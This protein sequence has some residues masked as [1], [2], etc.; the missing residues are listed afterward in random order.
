MRGLGPLLRDA[1]RLTLPYFRSEER[2]VAL[3]LLALVVG[4]SLGIVGINVMLSYWSRGFFDA[5]QAK[6]VDSFIRLLLL[7][8][9]SDDSLQF[10]FTPLA[11]V[12]VV[13]GIYRTYLNQ[14]LQIR[15]RNWLT[16]QLTCDWLSDRAYWRIALS[17][18]NAGGY[19]TD[20]PDQRIA[21]DLK[22]FVEDTLELALGL[23]SST[24][25]LFSFVAILWTLS[26]PLVVLGVDIPGH[27]V[28]LA[29]MYAAVASV[30][31]EYVGRPLAGLM[32]RQ[33]RVE[34]D[35]R[36]GLARLRENME[37]I[38]LYGGEAEE[39][40]SA[41][42]R[43]AAVMA[44]WRQIMTRTKLL[45]AVMLGF[46]QTAVIFPYLIAAPTY[47]A[48]SGT[49]GGMMQT[50]R[51][52]GQVERAMLWFVHAYQSLA[53]WRATVERLAAFSEAIVA[54]RV[55]DRGVA[56]VPGAGTGYEVDHLTLDLPDGR[57]LV[58]DQ[59]LSMLP[60]EWVALAGRSG[61][62]KST[63]FRALA[64]IWPFGAGTVREPASRHLFLPQRPYLP[65]GTL[66]RA[67][68]YPDPIDAHGDAAVLEVLHAVGLGHL[69]ASLDT[70]EPWTQRLSGGEQQRIAIARALLI[71]PDWLFLDEATSSLD[72]QSE[73]ELY[74]LLRQ[75][76]P[77]AA[78][79]SIAH[80][81]AVAELHARHIV[82]RDGALVPG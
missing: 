9:W 42:Q 60:G 65:L 66:R 17:A 78:I 75:R 23:L 4:L 31:T 14:M 16:A 25:T 57:R 2:W 70:E 39:Q 38:A 81:P 49:F 76:L 61:T 79:I 7:W 63:L 24:V 52:F 20:N 5:I 33:Q 37:G 8:K 44:N 74:E 43:F 77:H 55:A 71:K 59:A 28:W 6:D 64:G 73:A 3:G 29:L 45:N 22:K 62:G 56:L 10:G 27:M 19:G 53:D 12:Y 21:E 13:V 69:E 32:F 18:G 47:F 68:C 67:L 82:L 36:F 80:R 35:F 41:L 46:D 15:W 40:R 34:A 72:P 54:A 1:W 30:A 50:T 51:T 26:G 48:G 58:A 11:A